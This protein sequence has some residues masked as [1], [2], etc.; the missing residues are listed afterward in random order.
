MLH[1]V[2][3]IMAA[4]PHSRIA[5]IGQA[6]GRIVH[7][8]G[9]P[10]D[11]KSGERLREWL[12]VDSATFYDPEIF[13]LVPMGFCYPGTG[14]SGDLAPRR[15]CAPQWHDRLFENMKDLELLILIGTYAQAYYLKGTQKGT[16][17]ETVRHFAEYLP[18]HFVLPH[19]SPRNNIWL[20]KNPWFGQ[21]VLPV[22][23]EKV[24]SILL[25]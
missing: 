14:S 23:R 7:Q 25:S 16:L 17:T 10:W 21:E 1:G 13:A 22:L 15:E 19:P 4:H 8:T 9:I 24:D 18:A 20:K 5:I 12:G 11:D 2:R 6:P 3:P